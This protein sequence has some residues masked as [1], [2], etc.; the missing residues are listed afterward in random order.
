MTNLLCRPLLNLSPNHGDNMEKRW[1]LTDGLSNFGIG[2]ILMIRADNSARN[3]TIE[4]L[5]CKIVENNLDDT[6]DAALALIA[7]KWPQYKE[8]IPGKRFLRRFIANY[9]ISPENESL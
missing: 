3:S 2:L 5:G 6:L 8:L 1:V 4:L 9:R 7:T